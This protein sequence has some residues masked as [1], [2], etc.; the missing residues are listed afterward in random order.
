[1]STLTTAS[2]RPRRLE[3]TRARVLHVLELGRDDDAVVVA[4]AARQ[5]AQELIGRGV[6]DGNPAR[7]PLEAAEWRE[8]I[9]PVVGYGGR[10]QVGTD[11]L[12]LLLDRPGL[13]IHHHDPAGG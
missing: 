12:D 3:R 7:Q 9:L 2:A 5:D 6:D 11:A 10:L 8:Q 13:G 4:A 1:M